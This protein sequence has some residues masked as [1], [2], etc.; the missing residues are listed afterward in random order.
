MT[1]LRINRKLNF[2]IPVE[3][4]DG[5]TVYVHATPVGRETFES[6]FDVFGRT[7]TQIYSG[8]YG[9]TSGPRIAK[10][11]LAQTA[12]SI[13]RLDGPMGVEAALF[14]EVRRLTNVVLPQN[15]RWGTIPFEEAVKTELFNED[16]LSEVENAICFFILASAMNK[17]SEL[18][19]I[20]Q[21]VSSLWGAQV[22]SSNCTEF[23]AS[24]ATSIPT[25]SSGEKATPS[26][27][28]S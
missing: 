6:F 28:P 9:F 4:D 19:S 3:L 25:D 26:S 18:V 14:P 27:I 17:K 16:D 7:F 1:N 5:A 24:L 21:A 8:G 22:E 2:V 20:L 11:I 12:K 23:A 13:G 15:G 10:L